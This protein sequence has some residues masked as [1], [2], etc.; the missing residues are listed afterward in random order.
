MEQAFDPHT[1]IFDRS[2]WERI[3]RALIVYSASLQADKSEAAETERQYT[4]ALYGDIDF[5]L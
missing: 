5:K 1:F 2:D 4:L 3:K